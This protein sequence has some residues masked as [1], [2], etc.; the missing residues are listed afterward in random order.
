MCVQYLC[1]F[2]SISQLRCLYSPDEQIN[3][4]ERKP[5]VHQRVQQPSFLT[6]V[7]GAVHPNMSTVFTLPQVLPN[8]HE[9]PVLM[10]TKQ[11]ILQKAENTTGVQHF[12]QSLL[13]Q[14]IGM[15]FSVSQCLFMS[16]RRFSADLQMIFR[17]QR[18]RA[19]TTSPA[20]EP[21]LPEPRL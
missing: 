5:S 7:L 21:A 14:E 3:I 16:T 11:D 10:N 18:S 6:P 4:T 13:H 2:M 15:I 12:P 17:P 19:G 1:I 20:L 8:L 9:F